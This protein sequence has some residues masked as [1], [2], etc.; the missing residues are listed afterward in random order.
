MRVEDFACAST[1]FYINTEF[2][3]VFLNLR[4]LSVHEHEGTTS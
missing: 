2:G 1:K 4:P 3:Y